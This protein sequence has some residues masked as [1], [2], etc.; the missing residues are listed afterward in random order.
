MLIKKGDKIIVLSGKDKNKKSKVLV[1]YPKTGKVLVEAVN[2]TKRHQ[3][4]RKEGE[5]GQVVSVAMPID[6]SS[7]ALLC[8][9]CDKGSRVKMKLV[10]GKKLLVCV[11]CGSEF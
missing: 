1:A 7:V 6:A 11:R 5:K 2:M 10:G 8:S 9:K 3:R 4:T